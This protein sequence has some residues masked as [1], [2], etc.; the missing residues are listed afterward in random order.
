[1][2]YLILMSNFHFV[3]FEAIILGVLQAKNYCIFLMT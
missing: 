3:Y 2:K 1:M